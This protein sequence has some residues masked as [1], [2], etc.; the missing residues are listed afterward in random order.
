VTQRNTGD[1][2]HHFGT[3][4]AAAPVSLWKSIV[5]TPLICRAVRD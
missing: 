5:S 3:G 1:R 2:G 4:L